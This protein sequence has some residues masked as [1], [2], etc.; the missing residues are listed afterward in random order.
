MTDNQPLWHLV[1]ATTI[2]AIMA[3]I[4]VAVVYLGMFY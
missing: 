2:V 3:A 4:P 1:I